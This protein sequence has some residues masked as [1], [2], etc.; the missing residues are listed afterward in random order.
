MKKRI[1]FLFC[2]LLLCP[3]TFAYNYS[4]EE[5]AEIYNG[6]IDGYLKGIDM[7]LNIMQVPADK[8][9]EIKSFMKQNINKQQLI[10]E[11]WGCIQTKE[12]YD[13]MGLQQCFMPWGQRK[14]NEL[15]NYIMTT[16]Q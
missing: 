3:V 2:T 1:I 7:Q 5:K 10:N 12:P 16:M 15:V 11:T 9:Q 13:V 4:E 14:S 8:K 6:F